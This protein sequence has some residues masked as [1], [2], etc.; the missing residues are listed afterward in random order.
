MNVIELCMSTH[1]HM[2]R[3]CQGKPTLPFVRVLHN[4]QCWY[5]FTLSSYFF[6][7]MLMTL[8]DVPSSTKKLFDITSMHVHH[9]M[10]VYWRAWVDISYGSRNKLWKTQFPRGCTFADP[11]LNYLHIYHCSNV[12]KFWHTFDT[13][14]HT[15]TL[16]PSSL[17]HSLTCTH[18]VTGNTEITNV[19]VCYTAN[20]WLSTST[21]YAHSQPHLTSLTITCTQLH[22]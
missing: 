7:N 5:S 4:R 20:W 17:P 19:N 10:M 15:H 16:T 9:L 6:S 14:M 13:L 2:A 12:S 8:L 11:S 1:I 21:S 18:V 22:N 3:T